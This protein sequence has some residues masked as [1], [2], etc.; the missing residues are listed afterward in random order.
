MNRA[1]FEPAA[2]KAENDSRFVLIVGPRSVCEE[3]KGRIGRVVYLA[4]QLYTVVP[5]A[6]ITEARRRSRVANDRCEYDY[7]INRGTV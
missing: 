2:S 7:C 1:A 5:G 4:V 3:V 6:S